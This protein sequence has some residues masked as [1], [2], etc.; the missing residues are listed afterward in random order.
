L[1]WILGGV[2]L[3]LVVV[4]VVVGGFVWPAWFIHKPRRVTGPAVGTP[5]QVVQHLVDATNSQDQDTLTQLSCYPSSS[6][7]PAYVNKMT[8][9]HV[10][11]SLIG[12]NGG[13][14]DFTS[15]IRVTDNGQETDY[16]ISW[17]QQQDDSTCMVNV[18][19]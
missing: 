5:Q 18:Q 12:I 4:I 14:S 10:T 19:P 8:T 9:D 3:I 15:K 11:A 6:S 17:H 2:A 16:V 1:P 7:V 13:D